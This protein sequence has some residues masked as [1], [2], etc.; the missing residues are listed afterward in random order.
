MGREK[1]QEG[2]RRTGACKCTT[3][4]S[5][6]GDHARSAVNQLEGSLERC[7]SSKGNAPMPNAS[8]AAAAAA[9]LAPLALALVAEALQPHDQ[10]VLYCRRG[11][12]WSRA[13]C[14]TWRGL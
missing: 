5:G 4:Q 10:Q 8:S 3:A 9:H 11:G 1:Q 14:E 7:P 2:E 6:L 13:R 12:I